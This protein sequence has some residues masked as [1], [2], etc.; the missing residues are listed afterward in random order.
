MV[1]YGGFHTM[2]TKSKDY[3]FQKI[4]PRWQSF[5]EEQPLVQGGSGSVPAQVLRARHVPLPL[6]VGAAH[7]PPRGLHGHGH[8]RALQAGQ[9]LRRAPPDGLGR[10][11]PARRA[12]CGQDGHPPR[13]QHPE[14]HRQLQA[15]DQGPR[16]LLRLGPRDRHDRPQV[17]PVDAVDL[18]AA[19]PAGAWPTSTSAR[20]GGAR[21][22]APCSRTRR[23]S[24]ARARWGASPSSAAACASGC[25]GSRPTPT[26]C[27]PG[28]TEV[29]WP[30]STKRMQA[31]WIGRSEGA[32]IVFG[33]EDPSLGGLR[34]FT[35]RPDT[36]FGCTYMVLAPEHP[37]VGRPHLARRSGPPSRPTAG[38]PPRRAISSGPTSPR[39]KPGS[40][41]APTRSIPSTAPGCPSGSPTTCSS[42]YGTGAIMAVPA[43]DERDY[44][45]ATRY[46]LPIVA[47]IEPADSPAGDE[48]QAALH[49]R[50]PPRPI[51]RLYGPRLAGGQA[52]DDRRP[53]GK[54]LGARPRSTT[55]CA[56]GSSRASATGASRSRSSGSARPTISR[57]SGARSPTCCRG[58]PSAS[59]PT[60]S[61]ATP[62]RCP[63]PR[64][65][66]S[67]PRSQ[68]YLPSG[69][70]ESPLANVTEWVDIWYNC[71][72]GKAVRR[73]GSETRGRP[74]G[75]GAARDQHDAPV[76]RVVLVLPAV[77]RSAQRPRPGLARGAG[78]LGRARPLR[79]RRRAR[80][81]PPS[82]RAILAQGAL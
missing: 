21:K 16:V 48:A 53:R 14:Q 40:S 24:T 29:D 46:S 62:C 69:T 32:E 19:L 66:S 78:P 25:C 41:R 49:R 68:S 43:H 3:D 57:R 15:P 26:A 50:G 67:F 31:A 18:P 10:L 72:T 36:L 17:F 28:S 5:W 77:P 7:R 65:R 1:H 81:P 64:C 60:A 42:G 82:L 63:S 2:A 47:V 56:T 27:S 23:S 75:A 51:R 38:R 44:E 37:L 80:R 33:L 74:M 6:G 13:C 8:H 52:A 73:L 30:D 71:A 59:R 34:V 79:R 45:F 11:R 54:G 35:T 61:S 12:A 4:E 39:R 22:C 76:G 70:G 9:G 55:S 20:S 58:S